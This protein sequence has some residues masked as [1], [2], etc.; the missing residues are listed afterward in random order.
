M[1]E[2]KVK[3]PKC[4]GKVF[5]LPRE[6]V[7]DHDKITCAKCGFTDTY[8]RIA[9]PTVDKLMDDAARDIFKGFS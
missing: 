6:D 1:S 2:I 7:R 5:D 3:C 8:E 9:G 4:G